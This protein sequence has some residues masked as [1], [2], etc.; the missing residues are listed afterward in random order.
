MAAA[1]SHPADCSRTYHHNPVRNSPGDN[2]P[3]VVCNLRA[4]AGHSPLVE[5][6][7]NPLPAEHSLPVVV[8]HNLL[9]G[10]EGSLPLAAHNPRVEAAG[11][12]LQEEDNLPVAGRSP[13][14]EV[15]VVHNP[16]PVE[17]NLRAA[18]V[19]ARNPRVVAVEVLRTAAVNSPP[20]EAEVVR[21]LLVAVAHSLP[22]AEH[23]CRSHRR[24]SIC[25]DGPN[26]STNV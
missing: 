25:H 20:E 10:E 7:G 1:R 14:V 18:A 16:L 12:L 21:N 8:D 26:P 13:Q 15:V 23:H 4:A 9:V 17:H 19:E 3:R 6:V 22:A 5:V 2:L 11:S 24:G